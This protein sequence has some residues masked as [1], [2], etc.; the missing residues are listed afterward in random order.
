MRVMRWKDGLAIRL[1][2]SVIDALGLKEVSN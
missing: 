1:P 2:R